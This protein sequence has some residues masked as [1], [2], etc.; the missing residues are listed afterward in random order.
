MDVGNDPFPR[1]EVT[2]L[3]AFENLEPVGS[4]SVV[5]EAEPP[6]AAS[7]PRLRSGAVESALE[8]RADA[9][10]PLD[11]TAEQ[12]EEVNADHLFDGPSPDW[13]GVEEATRVVTPLPERTNQ[14]A[15]LQMDWDED[16][17]PTRMRESGM[18]HMSPLRAPVDWDARH[19]AE[20]FQNDAPE[21]LPVSSTRTM[22]GGQPSPFPAAPRPATR[23]LTYGGSE[24]IGA[25]SPFAL[26]RGEGFIEALKH[27]DR[28]TW[29]L[30]GGGAAGLIVL[31]LIIRGVFGSGSLGAVTF[32]TEPSDA[33]VLVDGKEVSGTSS[34]FSLSDVTAGRHDVL[35]QKQ[36]YADYRGTF[37]LARGEN[38]SMPTVEL[39]PN[40]REVGFSIRSAPA[41]ADVWVDGKAT[42][43]VTPARLTGVSAGIHRLQLKR[44]GFATYE[45]QMFVP[46]ATVLQLPT[47]EL[48]AAAPEEA[49]VAHAEAEKPKAQSSDDGDS[50]RPAHASRTKSS[51]DGADDGDGASASH[52]SHAKANTGASSHSPHVA[53]SSPFGAARP[54]ASAAPMAPMLAAAAPAPAAAGGKLGTLRLNTRPWAQ[55]IV[56]GRMVGNTPQPNLQLPAGKHKIQLVNPAMGLS[57][58]VSVTIKAGQVTTQ[59]LNL[60]E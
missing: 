33:T 18:L 17:P 19:D 47:A 14:S 50:P 20:S 2:G 5:P 42:D 56:D 27:G 46:D 35:I 16:E 25:P 4:M 31:A 44:A 13:D 48:T 53:S 7:Q 37:N 11:L 43:Q 49:P 22:T 32:S 6:A 9:T 51:P 28:R 38:K 39:T 8:N 10:L 1:E 12:Q 30:A 58:N 60:A 59:V 15:D 55:V 23:E 36:G 34:P 40:V 21:R 3:A 45:L 26:D 24:G 41:G 54:G 29:L 57:K 52:G